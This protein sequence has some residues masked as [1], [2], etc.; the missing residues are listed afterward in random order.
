M[1][2]FLFFLP[3]FHTN[4]VPWVRILKQGGH[5]VEMHC[6]IRGHTEDYSLIAPHIYEQSTLSRRVRGGVERDKYLFPKFGDVY[7]AMRKAAPDIV[8]VRG[9]TRWFMRMAALCAIL[10]R[11]RLVVYDQEEQTPPFSTTW[12]RRA[13][14]RAIGIAHFTPKVGVGLHEDAS[15]GSALPVP[16]GRPFVQAQLPRVRSHA[17]PRILMVS[18]YRERKR[19][20][21]LLRALSSL[22]EPYKFTLTLCGEEASEED[23]AYC[24]RLAKLASE[25]GL[26]NRLVFRNN[27]PHDKM[28]DVYFEHDVF[29]LPAVNEPAAIS[30]LEAAWCGCAVL[31]AADSGTRN[32]I[33]PGPQYEFAARD[34]NSLGHALRGMLENAA[35][36]AHAQ[37]ECS[38]WIS[39]L[40]SDELVLERM[41]RLLK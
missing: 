8:V 9:L 4:A 6:V 23:S 40:A 32:Y 28:T 20:E 36:V 41:E 21:D 11:R 13:L 2:K 29:V 14:C 18:K 5:D 1:S 15:W 25:L 37:E 33:P 24:R 39:G 10:Q 12:M 35:S 27:V 16:F 26:A 34:A 22:P 17:V 7:S 19:H 31:I 3:R 30:P 38:R